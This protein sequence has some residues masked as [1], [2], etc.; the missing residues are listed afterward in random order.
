VLW[1]LATAG[2]D[3]VQRV[4]DLIISEFDQAMA[5]SGCATVDDITADLLTGDHTSR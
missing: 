5:L 3:G 2:A 1:G 4:L